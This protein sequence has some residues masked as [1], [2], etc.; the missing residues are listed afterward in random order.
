[1]YQ[2]V[3]ERFLGLK[4]LLTTPRGAENKRL[5]GGLGEMGADIHL[6]VDQRLEITGMLTEA[7]PPFLESPKAIKL[8]TEWLEFVGLSV[9]GVHLRR[10][11][12]HLTVLCLSPA[13]S[14]E[15]RLASKIEA[16][17]KVI[18]KSNLT[19]LKLFIWIILLVLVEAAALLSLDG[20]EVPDFDISVVL[21]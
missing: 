11:D 5:G 1:M 18:L 4:E 3:H 6:F 19:V 20:G 8:T 17:D 7:R 9:L 12:F 13:E 15:I 14:T 10:G 2:A 21:E 16:V